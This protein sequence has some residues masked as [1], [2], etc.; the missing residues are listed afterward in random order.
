MNEVDKRLDGSDDMGYTTINKLPEDWPSYRIQEVVNSEGSPTEQAIRLISTSL[1][2][3][4]VIADKK[5]I[6]K[7]SDLIERGLQPEPQA[8]NTVTADEYEMMSGVKPADL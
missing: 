7:E 3:D 5:L 4:L 6:N 1:G 8:P 2:R